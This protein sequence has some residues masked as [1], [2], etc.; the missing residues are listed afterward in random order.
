M[1]ASHPWST[2]AASVAA[3]VLL[4]SVAP[5]FGVATCAQEQQCLHRAPSGIRSAPGVAHDGTY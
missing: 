1:A 2:V 5:V 3:A 4:W